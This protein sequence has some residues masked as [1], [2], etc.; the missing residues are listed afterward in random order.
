[1]DVGFSIYIRNPYP[2]RW[3]TAPGGAVQVF[4]FTIFS[5]L[6]P[7]D[8]HPDRSAYFQTPRDDAG[9]RG[10]R[11]ESS[12]CCILLS[13]SYAS[14]EVLTELLFIALLFQEYDRKM[15]C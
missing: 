2:S 7:G 15:Q 3:E 13:K 10:F 1:V 5:R 14:F 9:N 8:E 12:S 4:V 11:W 6:G